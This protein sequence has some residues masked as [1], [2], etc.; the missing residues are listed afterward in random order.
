MKITRV[1]PLAGAM[2]EVD[3]VAL[4]Q[5]ERVLRGLLNP[6]LENATRLSVIEQLVEG[7]M[8]KGA[9]SK[10]MRR[11]EINR[12]PQR[13]VA[14][15]HIHQNP[16]LSEVAKKLT[17][18]QTRV[19]RDAAREPLRWLDRLSDIQA[20]RH[21]DQL[22]LGRYWPQLSQGPFAAPACFSINEQ[23]LEVLDSHKA[24]NDGVVS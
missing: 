24:S 1:D 2:V 15:R 19:L 8:L 7:P 20:A 18:A 3:L 11:A 4:R 21:L 10:E 6:E 23:G 14:P 5:M 9:V 12:L 17:S 16:D 13:Q 22:D